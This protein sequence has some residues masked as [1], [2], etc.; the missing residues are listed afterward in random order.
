MY[1]K[2]IQIN[3][4]SLEILPLKFE[5]RHPS[6]CYFNIV[7]EILVREQNKEWMINGK[8]QNS[9]LQTYLLTK[10]IQEY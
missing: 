2:P 4:E 5:T 8:K 3:S 10:K 7:L 9:F 1:S 6:Y